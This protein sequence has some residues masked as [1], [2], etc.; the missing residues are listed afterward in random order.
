MAS[1]INFVASRLAFQCVLYV[2]LF[3]TDEC[4]NI[5][6]CVYEGTG[7]LGLFTVKKARGSFTPNVP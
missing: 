3:M 7:D 4:L 1:K 5:V 2:A 6:L